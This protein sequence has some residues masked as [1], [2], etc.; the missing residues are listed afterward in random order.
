MLREGKKTGSPKLW[1][2]SRAV[3]PPQNKTMKHLNG[4]KRGMT[5]KCNNFDHTAVLTILLTLFDFFS[6]QSPLLLFTSTIQKCFVGEGGGRLLADYTLMGGEAGVETSRIFLLLEGG[7]QH[8]PS[9]KRDYP[10][11]ACF[12]RFMK[13][14]HLPNAIHF[15][16]E[17]MRSPPPALL[18]SRACV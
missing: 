5:N 15:S 9:P 17:F 14:Q 2:F 3:K 11:L 13:R 8:D 10:S 16:R 6:P 7:G 12:L 1:K 4:K 18:N